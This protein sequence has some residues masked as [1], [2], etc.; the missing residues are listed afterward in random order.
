MTR[1]ELVRAQSVS[2]PEWVTRRKESGDLKGAQRAI[3]A[4]LADDALPRMVRA[5]LMVEKERLRRLP[6]QY[7]DSR[8][9]DPGTDPVTVTVHSVSGGYLNIMA[10]LYRAEGSSYAHCIWFEYGISDNGS[11]LTIY[12]YYDGNHEN[13]AYMAEKELE[14]SA[15]IFCVPVYALLKG[16]PR[17]LNLCLY[18]LE[19]ADGDPAVVQHT[20]RLYAN[21]VGY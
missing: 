9:E 20:Y 8:E 17:L 3:D 2:L 6:T 11:E 4:L 13:P 18:E 12:V 1:D 19:T 14:E 16:T 7:P 5:R 10:T 21:S 15:H